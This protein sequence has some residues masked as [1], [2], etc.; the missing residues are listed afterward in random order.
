[1]RDTLQFNE[2][3]A[4]NL[5]INFTTRGDFGPPCLNIGPVLRY[6]V[7]FTILP[8]SP[9][10][11]LYHFSELA[12]FTIFTYRINLRRRLCW[13]FKHFRASCRDYRFPP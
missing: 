7:G 5:L 4:V 6:H 9:L 3:R 2:W 10:Y 13:R 1:M 8:I 12:G 11:R